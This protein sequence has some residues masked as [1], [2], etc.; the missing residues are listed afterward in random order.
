VLFF[1]AVLPAVYT[2][3]VFAKA[4]NLSVIWNRAII[5]LQAFQIRTFNK[6]FV[7]GF[8]V[9]GRIAKCSEAT[10]N[11]DSKRTDI[12]LNIDTLLGVCLLYL[13][14]IISSLLSYLFERQRN[15]GEQQHDQPPSDILYAKRSGRLSELM[16]P[17][18]HRQQ[19]ITPAQRLIQLVQ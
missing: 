14:G 18:H 11:I 16:V 5:Q 8:R 7:D 12:A 1:V 4:N 3:F 19:S 6:Y 10:N 17:M 13:C 15:Q 9:G 2:H